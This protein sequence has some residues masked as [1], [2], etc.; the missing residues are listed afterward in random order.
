MRI[1]TIF[2]LYILEMLLKLPLKKVLKKEKMFVACFLVLGWIRIRMFLKNL[3]HLSV[4][5]CLFRS[6]VG[7]T[8][9]SKFK[10]LDHV[11]EINNL[12]EPVL[13]VKLKP[14]MCLQ[15]VQR[16]YRTPC[17]LPQVPVLVKHLLSFI[18]WLI[19]HRILYKSNI[20]HHLWIDWWLTEY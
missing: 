9:T 2:L 7:S 13:Q 15:M 10:W 11:N 19:A 14:S 8:Y 3:Q 16:Q 17:K 12:I 18:D 4:I 20:C 6:E 5:F 1:P